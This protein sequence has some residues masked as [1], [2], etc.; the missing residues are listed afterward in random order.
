ML[1]VEF[2]Q[3]SV[4]VT[5]KMRVTM[6]P[7]V[8]SMC[9]TFVVT[10]LQLS[11]AVT[12]DA[13]PASVGGLA[14]LQPKLLPMGTITKGFAVSRMVIVWLQVALLPQASVAR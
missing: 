5:V 11:L 6:Q 4:A 14:G 10:A 7:L 8:V 1:V 12:C 3:V 2:V 9:V 13:T